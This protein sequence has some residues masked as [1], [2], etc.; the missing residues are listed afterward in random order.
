MKSLT[1]SLRLGL[2]AAAVSLAGTASFADWAPVTGANT[3][4]YGGYVRAASDANGK[5]WVLTEGGGLHKS[6]DGGATWAASNT[7]LTDLRVRAGFISKGTTDDS[8]A[9]VFAGTRGA[10]VFK[11]T[12]GGASFA[13]INGGLNCTYVTALTGTATRLFAGTDCGSSSGVYYSDV[14]SNWVLGTGMPADIKVNSVNQI[15]PSGTGV[16]Y[17]LASTE[18]GI[19]KSTDSGASWTKLSANPTGLNGS[20]VYHVRYLSYTASGTTVIRLIAT[21]EGAGVFISENSGVTWTASNTGLPSN[22]NPLG[23]VSFNG[24]DTLFLSL[25]GAGTYKSNDRGNSW[26]LFAQESALPNARFVFGA[27]PNFY[28]GTVAGPFKS[29]DGGTTWTKGGAGLSG[30]I[31]TRAMTD[32]AGKWYAAAADGVYQ[33]DATTSQWSRMTGLPSMLYGSVMVRGTSV[34][35]TTDTAGIFKYNGTAWQAINNGLPP[36]LVYRQPSL[37]FDI[38]SA[39]AMYAGL[40]GD[41]VYYTT[42]DGATWT[43]RNT[44]LSGDA[45]KVHHMATAGALV[46]ISTEAGVYKSTDRGL[47]WVFAFAPRNNANTANKSASHV[48]IDQATPS[49]VYAGAFNTDAVGVSLA[50]NGVWKS[51]DSGANWT[52]LTSMAGKKV[53]DVRIIGS[54]NTLVAGVW[55]DGAA[56]GFF[57]S[58]DGGATWVNKSVG[59]SSN[60]IN[61]V[62]ASPVAN[63]GGFIA[64]RGAGLFSFVNAPGSSDWR[65]FGVWESSNGFSYGASFGTSSAGTTGVTLTGNGVAS[66]V[67]AQQNGG[68]WSANINFGAVQPP[69][70]TV[71]TATVTPATGA[72]VTSTFSMRAAGYN[73]RF[74]NSIQIAGGVNVTDA[75]PVITWAAPTNPASAFTYTVA[76][77]KVSDSQQVWRIGNLTGLTTTYAGPALVPGTQY[78]LEVQTEEFDTTTNATYGA[79]RNFQFCFQCTANPNGANFDQ[80]FIS[81]NMLTTGENFGMGVRY[82]RTAGDGNAS[83]SIVCP[84]T[85]AT[86]T[87]GAVTSATHQWANVNFGNTQPNTPFDCSSTVT[88][89]NGTTNVAT[90]TVDGFASNTRY[91]TNLSLAANANVTSLSGIT[92]ALP[93]GMGLGD[94]V[95]ANVYTQ[96]AQGFSDQ[97]IWFISNTAT[98]IDVSSMPALTANT[99]YILMVAVVDSS[100]RMKAAQMMVPFCFQCTSTGGGTGTGTG[101]GGSVPVVAGWNLL[102]NSNSAAMDVATVLGNASNVTSVWKWIPASGKW[103]F[104]APSMDA[105]TLATYA[106]GKGYDVLS[107]VAGGEGFWV[108]AKNAFTITLPSGTAVT[109]SSFAATLPLSWSLIAIGDNKTPRAFN[110]ALSQ[111]PPAAGVLASSILTSLWAWDSSKSA[112]YFYAPALDNNGTLASYSAGKGYLDVGTNTIQP[113]VGFW[114]NKQ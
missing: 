32:S 108:N 70:N 66:A 38:T 62:T 48:W 78:R 10:G 26:S 33:R 3:P 12:N 99:K 8:D 73:I 112:W 40:Y 91:V 68:N 52:Q 9:K 59:L 24:V 22:P 20:V 114:V 25:S 23:G 58:N 41:G 55:D 103:A 30:G 72:P 51:T 105:A 50:S 57:T 49:T 44:G 80:T 69:V 110:N 43:A 111:T 47:N 28:A 35:A 21:V 61:S 63:G 6:T 19:Y 109:S 92:F 53:K 101:T 90:I 107:S 83:Y 113:G 97:Q 29:T 74:P 98:P 54:D 96:N 7:G 71:Y 87:F 36:N 45:L 84:N 81:R 65:Y 2:V 27:S 34:Y 106:A 14:G 85:S 60:L 64:T 1:H 11:S 15:N 82:P 67:P 39:T 95:Q 102:G 4:G 5:L 46:Y 77:R 100:N 104:Y 42:D 56:G 79:G 86:G 13:A 93:Q 18:N 88:Y 17:L 31:T 75:A 76:I 16:D 94:R 89:G 37:R